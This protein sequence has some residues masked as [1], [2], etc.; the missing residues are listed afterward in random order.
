M[1]LKTPPARLFFNG[2]KA[3][4]IMRLEIME[5]T[6]WSCLSKGIG[7]KMTCE[8][9]LEDMGLRDMAGKAVA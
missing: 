8:L 5:S 4:A 1:V 2:G 6:G 3:S 9:P 7:I